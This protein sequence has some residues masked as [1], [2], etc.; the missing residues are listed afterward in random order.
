MPRRSEIAALEARRFEAARRFARGES[1]AAVARALGVTAVAAHR[2]FQSWHAKGQAG[3]KA[4]GR[5]G[6]KPRLDAEQLA[7]LDATLRQGP[8]TPGVAT[9]LWTLPPPSAD[10]EVRPLLVSTRGRRSEWQCL[11]GFTANQTGVPSMIQFGEPVEIDR[12]RRRPAAA[13]RSRHSASVRIRPPVSTS[14]FTSHRL[15][16]DR[17]NPFFGAERVG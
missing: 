12:V 15:L 8:P 7:Q 14:M 16:P 9:D 17:S 6:R 4:A 13:N 1:Q 3:L 10:L 2:W 11:D 5:L